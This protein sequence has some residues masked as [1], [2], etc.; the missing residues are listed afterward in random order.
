MFVEPSKTKDCG[1][2][3]GHVEIYIEN[4]KVV[5]ITGCDAKVD[6]HDKD[7]EQTTTMYFKKQEY[8]YGSNKD[9]GLAFITDDTQEKTD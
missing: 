4:D 6:V 7:I 5:K 3:N 9:N 8:E 1:M 2:I